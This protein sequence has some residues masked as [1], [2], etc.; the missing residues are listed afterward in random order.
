M[1]FSIF[2]DIR[3][4]IA[5]KRMLSMT[6]HHA[7]MLTDLKILEEHLI[8][9]FTIQMIAVISKPIQKNLVL[10]VSS[11]NLL[12]QHMKDSIT[13]SSTKQTHVM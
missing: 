10:L 2:I 13:L 11:A 9:S 12:I 4:L 3:L 5:H 7:S 1:I 6:G 8:S